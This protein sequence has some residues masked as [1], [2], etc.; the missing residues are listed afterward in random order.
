MSAMK[1]GIAMARRPLVVRE[2]APEYGARTLSKEESMSPSPLEQPGA[3]MV[4]RQSFAVLRMVGRDNGFELGSPGILSYRTRPLKGSGRFTVLVHGMTMWVDDSVSDAVVTYLHN[5]AAAELTIECND[6]FAIVSNFRSGD[7]GIHVPRHP[8]VR[9]KR[10][11]ID[12]K[13]AEEAFGL[14]GRRRSERRSG[15]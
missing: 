13:E 5:A 6:D 10:A 11:L 9:R 2:R 4:A 3:N 1:G 15:Q 14:R 8:T 12:R 7:L